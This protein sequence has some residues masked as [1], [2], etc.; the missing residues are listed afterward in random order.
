MTLLPGNLTSLLVGKKNCV[1]PSGSLTLFSVYLEVCEGFWFRTAAG[2][3]VEQVA[4]H[5]EQEK[6][7]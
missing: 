2:G 5:V 6:Y 1:I 4:E 3:L 7:G